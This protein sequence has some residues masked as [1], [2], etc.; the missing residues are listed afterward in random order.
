MPSSDK[1]A[2]RAFKL[3]KGISVRDL[4]TLDGINDVVRE[5]EAEKDNVSVAIVA[6]QYKD[7]GGRW[8]SN[9][10]K[11]K[12]IIWLLEMIRF[13]VIDEALNGADDEEGDDAKSI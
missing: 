11:P 2:K 6:V 8:F 12:D 1:R 9:R 4:L 3:P 10:A 7:G 5:L 13:Q